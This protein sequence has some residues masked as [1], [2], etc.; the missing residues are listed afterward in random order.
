MLLI[1]RTYHA[2]IV[3]S[4][5]VPRHFG[6]EAKKFSLRMHTPVSILCQVKTPALDN[7]IKAR[8]EQGYSSYNNNCSLL[9]AYYA[10]IPVTRRVLPT[11]VGDG[12]ILPAN[13]AN[14]P[15]TTLLRPI[16]ISE[17]VSSPLLIARR[18]DLDLELA[19]ANFFLHARW[20][21]IRTIEH[22]Q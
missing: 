9:L 10:G 13:H 21:V 15:P 17:V 7:Q 6:A 14:R 11:L 20:A 16:I 1:G 4:S 19:R 2:H 8:E 22:A 12:R 5:T 3:A 18:P